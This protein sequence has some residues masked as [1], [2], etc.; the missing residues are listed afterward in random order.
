MK[1]EQTSIKPKKVGPKDLS[2]AKPKLT[3]AKKPELVGVPKN[4]FV[5]GSELA[6]MSKK[7]NRKGSN[8]LTRYRCT[9]INKGIATLENLTQRKKMLVSMHLTKDLMPIF[10]GMGTPRAIFNFKQ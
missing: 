1:K 5:I 4:V 2:S 7:E 6:V 8:A 10:L 9:S 3:Q